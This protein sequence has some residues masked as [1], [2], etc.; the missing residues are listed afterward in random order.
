MSAQPG[1]YRFSRPERGYT[2]I[3]HQFA[4]HRDLKPRAVKVGLYVLSHVE[5]FTQKQS[6]IAHALGMDETTVR[7]AMKDLEQHRFMVRHDVRDE[8]GYRV[9][10]AYAVTD[11]PFTDEELDQLGSPPGESP[12]GKI[13]AGKSPAPKK[14]RSR[15]D[16]T[17]GREDQPSGGAAGAAPVE[18]PVTPEEEPMPTATDPAQAQLFDVESPEP[19]PA[20][21][22]KPEGAQA[23]VAAYVEAWRDHNPEG[24][25][26]RSHKGR[27]ARDARAMLDKG[28]ATEEELVAAARAMAGTPFSNLGVQLNIHRRGRGRSA[29][30]G[31]SVPLPADHPSWAQ[32]AA[33]D[34]ARRAAKPVSPELEALRAQYVQAGVA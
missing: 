17:S 12:P 11:V 2:P 5:G 20:E 15:R 10:T 29:T 4:R 24:E 18:E 22:R 33:E 26:L 8:R 19:P 13:P 27:I 6:A 28:E 31:H 21:P 7:A 32:G 14:T 16:T 3:A 25:P 30:V 9:G 1:V 34:A 23:V